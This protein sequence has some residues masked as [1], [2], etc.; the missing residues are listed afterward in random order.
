MLGGS[1]RD[2]VPKTIRNTIWKGDAMTVISSAPIDQTNANSIRDLAQEQAG[3]SQRANEAKEKRENVE[4]DTIEDRVAITSDALQQNEA[5]NRS[6][7]GLA[8]PEPV[9]KNELAEKNFGQD[10]KAESVAEQRQNAEKAVKASFQEGNVQTQP[11]V[12]NVSKAASVVEQRAATS[13]A[14]ESGFQSGNTQTDPAATQK[15]STRKQDD[16]AG[17]ASVVQQRIE[18]RETLVEKS[19]KNATAVETERGQNVSKM[20]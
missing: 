19:T 12:T 11:V 9:R 7:G 5:V 1:P 6:R 13:A 16:D 8:K 20:I 15:F 17:A 4:P 18:H 3:L 10:G 2:W 14:L